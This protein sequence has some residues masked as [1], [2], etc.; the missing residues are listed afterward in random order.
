MMQGFAAV[1]ASA[2]NLAYTRTTA[3][4]GSEH[5]KFKWTETWKQA[6]TVGVEHRFDYKSGPVK[7]PFAEIWMQRKNTSNG[8]RSGGFIGLGFSF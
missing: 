8:P 3:A 5:A 1:G 2:A 4:V 7:H 6:Q